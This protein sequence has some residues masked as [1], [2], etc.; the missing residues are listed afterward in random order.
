MKK[1]N[2]VSAFLSL[3][4]VATLLAG[5]GGSGGSTDGSSA[6]KGK[7]EK[8]T[9][10][11][12]QLGAESQWRTANTKSVQD[13]AK[14]DPNVNL[15]FSD[16][17]QKQENQIS[18]IR[19]FIQQGVDV[20]AVAPVVETGWE[21]VLTEAKDANI[22]VLIVDRKMKGKKID[23]LYSAWIGT[24]SKDEG[25]RGIKWLEDQLKETGK[26]SDALNIAHLQG[27]TGSSAQ[28]GRTAGI[29]EGVK[30]HKNWK[31]IEQQSGNFTRAEGKEVMEAFMKSNGDNID[32]LFSENDDMA[33]GAIQAIE[34]V[35]KVPGKDIT[36]ISFDGT[37]DAL[38]QVVDGKINCVVECSPLYGEDIIETAKKL[39]KGEKVKKEVFVENGIFDSKNAEENLPR[40]Y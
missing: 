1:K 23:D 9:I 16:A 37:N 39:A 19:N 8:I 32:V 13:A 11:F 26:E 18:A 25:E 15:K 17:Q 10:G 4:L 21:T 14:N 40:P 24:D 12:S 38:E 3:T 20:I 5:C 34:E 33:M 2:L 6:K 29:T 22:P 27:T 28:V 35:G 30:K 36:V 31:I 7:D